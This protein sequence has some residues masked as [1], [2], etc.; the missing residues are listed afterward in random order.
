MGK[1]KKQTKF[2]L[3]ISSLSLPHPNPLCLPKIWVSCWRCSK[4]VT[5]L[6]ADWLGTR[7]QNVQQ[8][9]FINPFE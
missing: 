6:I 9:E 4:G 1:L 7:V 2:G 3:P 8:D 5:N